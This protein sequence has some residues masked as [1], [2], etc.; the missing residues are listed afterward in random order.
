MDSLDG[1]L[2]GMRLNRVLQRILSNGSIDLAARWILG[3]TFIYASFHK[4]IS[5]GAFAKIVFG[6]DIFPHIFINLIAI[7]VP[8]VELVTGFA[9]ISGIFTRSAAI[10]I[11]SMLIMFILLIS[12]NL[13][14]GH[15]F[16][17]GCFSVNGGGFLKSPSVT[18]FRDVFYFL[19]GLQII[20]F[21]GSRKGY[22]NFQI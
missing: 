16:D 9:L 22:F 10:I 6:Y 18:L 19:L 3:L 1:R 7:N 4:I 12:F 5:P 15:A 8:F 2:R 13:I 20:Y 21:K 17:C 11:N 14:R